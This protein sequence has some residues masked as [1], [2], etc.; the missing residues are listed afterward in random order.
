MPPFTRLVDIRFKDENI[1]R[2][3]LMESRLLGVLVSAGF[4]CLPGTGMIRVSL[5]K[6]KDLP[7]RKEMIL[8]LVD[9]F[10]K[11][12]HYGSGIAFDVDPL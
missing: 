1:K 11:E 8:R 3:G 7:A 9:R 6:N 5:K 4:D 2:A 10:E 12:N